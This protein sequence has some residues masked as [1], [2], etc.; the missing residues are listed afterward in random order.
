MVSSLL[1]SGQLPTLNKM[2]FRISLSFFSLL[3]WNIRWSTVCMPCLYVHC[4][5]CTWE[6]SKYSKFPHERLLALRQ[7]HQVIGQFTFTH[8]PVP[9]FKYNVLQNFS[10]I[11]TFYFTLLYFI[12]FQHCVGRMSAVKNGSRISEYFFVGL[13][14][15]MFNRCVNIAWWNSCVYWSADDETVY[16]WASFYTMLGQ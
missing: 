15:F 12:S 16:I 13:F 7:V 4:G 2:F 3:H 1:L 11:L 9:Y 10:L 8:W 14:M 6:T 5:C